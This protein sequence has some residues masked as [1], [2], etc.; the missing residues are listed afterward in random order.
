MQEA[1]R[2]SGTGKVLGAP[3]WCGMKME[4][5][6]RSEKRG[7]E[8]IESMESQDLYDWKWNFL[9]FQQI[10]KVWTMLNTSGTW[11]H[12]TTTLWSSDKIS[13][14]KRYLSTHR[15]MSTPKVA[16]NARLRHQDAR[17]KKPQ[18]FAERIVHA[19]WFLGWH[20]RVFGDRANELLEIL[21]IIAMILQS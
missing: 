13:F 19:H 1:G 11:R 12:S 16:Q 21:R 17:Y 7:I 3:E 18:R 6:W 9:S 20:G 2:S 10:C 8:L 15:R 14:I 4:A 5:L